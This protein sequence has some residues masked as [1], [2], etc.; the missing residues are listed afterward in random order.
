[1]AIVRNIVYGYGM[2][3]IGLLKAL[4]DNQL[5]GGWLNLDPDGFVPTVNHGAGAVEIRTDPDGDLTRPRDPHA[6]L[7]WIRIPY[8]AREVV[9]ASWLK[10]RSLTTL[11]GWHAGH[12]DFLSRIESEVGSAIGSDEGISQ[13][14]LRSLHNKQRYLAAAARRL[15]IPDIDYLD[16][17]Q[18]HRCG[19]LIERLLGRA[20][21]DASMFIRQHG[22]WRD[23]NADLLSRLGEAMA[24]MILKQPLVSQ[25]SWIDQVPRSEL[26]D[27]HVFT[28]R[29]RKIVRE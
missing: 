26:I 20:L 8:R 3:E 13:A 24:P 28:Q 19:L 29:V 16:I 22:R 7:F 17:V 6:K 12:A 4:C 9:V 23:G 2:E 21:P 5:S 14:L 18:C 10:R 11:D 25:G 15:G 27:C 1:M